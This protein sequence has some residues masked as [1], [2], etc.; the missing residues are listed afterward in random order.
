M[1]IRVLEGDERKLF[2]RLWAQAFNRG[3]R[4]TDWIG[5]GETD[6]STVYCGVFDEAGLQAC[7]S[8]IGY[9]V[10]FGE[11]LVLPM[12]GIGGVAC[13]PASRGKGYAGAL[14]KF[15]LETMKAN[16]QPISALFPFSWEF[17]R[18]YGYEWVGV[19]RDTKLPTRILSTSPETENV[20]LLE[21][22]EMEKIGPVYEKFAKGYRACLQRTPSLWKNFCTHPDDKFRYLY[23]A[24][25]N[26]EIEGYL[27]F[28]LPGD[29]DN[30]HLR[31]FVALTPRARRALLGLLKRHEMQFEFFNWKAP[32]DDPLWGEFYHWDIETKIR[33]VYMGRVVDAEAA[34]APLKPAPH[35]RGEFRLKLSDK[36]APWNEKTLRV[37]FGDGTVEVEETEAKP[38]L[39]MDIQAFS[40]LY[41]GTPDADFLLRAGRV[42]VD[43]EVAYHGLRS[44]LSGPP[45]FT[46]DHF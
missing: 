10:Y 31:E 17:Y 19:Q 16:R 40:Q 12:G 22:S 14:L 30:A 13:L 11:T 2:N 41:F 18:R 33:P 39:Q 15:A 36:H 21:D 28:T 37:A 27:N 32:E 23:A 43:D 5:D 42:A 44:L 45:V 24:E 20:R 9:H 6:L 8:I 25:F 38:N 1:E 3:R 4:S 26:G 46:N 29:G 34:L 35:F 7:L